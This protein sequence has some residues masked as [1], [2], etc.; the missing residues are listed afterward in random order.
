MTNRNKSLDSLLE[1]SEDFRVPDQ[2][3]ED[4]DVNCE[5]EQIKVHDGKMG[6]DIQ[7]I[8]LPMIPNHLVDANSISTDGLVE[9]EAK[10]D[11]GKMGNDIEEVDVQTPQNKLKVKS[12]ISPNS[13]DDSTQVKDFSQNMNASSKLSNKSCDSVVVIDSV[14]NK[15][16]H[17]ST[18][19][20]VKMSIPSK[21]PSVQTPLKM[22]SIPVDSNIITQNNSQVVLIP[23]GG[24]DSETLQTSLKVPPGQKIVIIK[25]QEILKTIEQKKSQK[26]EKQNLIVDNHKVILQT[27]KPNVSANQNIVRAQLPRVLSKTAV[28]PSSMVS[29]SKRVGQISGQTVQLLPLQPRVPSCKKGSLARPSLKPT[30]QRFRFRNLQT[31]G[32]RLLLR[33]LLI[34]LFKQA[35]SSRN[36][37]QQRLKP[38]CLYLRSI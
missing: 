30:V 29:Q 14:V 5:E 23:V 32:Q 4:S 7:E 20:S 10:K 3:F 6:S 11:D 25:P 27:I 16:T 24:M 15:E 9:V 8:E 18:S 13:Q 21:N 38:V 1:M 19:S 31:P 37:D 34:N 33:E 22:V 36:P 28:V 17:T 26:S 35:L 2:L 12:K